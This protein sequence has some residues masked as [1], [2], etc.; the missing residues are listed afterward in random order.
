MA[1]QDK[2]LPKN[3]QD[4]VNTVL[5]MIDSGSLDWTKGWDSPSYPLAPV[6]AITGTRYKGINNAM[7]WLTAIERGYKDNRWLTF[8]QMEQNGWSFKKNEDGTSKGKG[9]GVPV[10]LFRYYDSLTKKDLDWKEF[11]KLT[12]DEQKD[13]WDKNVRR[14]VRYH[15]VFNAELVDGIAELKD[16]QKEV[17]HLSPEERNEKAEATIRDWNDKQCSI[18]HNGGE[19]A[20]YRP[21]TDS[22]H[23]PERTRFHSLEDYYGTALHEIGHATGHAKRLNRDLTGGF[24]SENYAKE[25]LKAE[26]AS[27][28]I[29][30]E[31][32]LPMSEFHIRNH[33][34]YLQ[35]WKK[36]ITNNPNVLFDAIKDAGKITSYVLENATTLQSINSVSIEENF[37]ESREE[38]SSSEKLELGKSKWKA[39]HLSVECCKGT[40]DSRCEFTL[41][42]GKYAGWDFSHPSKLV[43]DGWITD[44]LQSDTHKMCKDVIYSDNYS[45]IL[46]NGGKFVK[47]S[48]KELVDSFDFSEE[49]QKPSASLIEMCSQ[50]DTSSPAKS[51][52][53]RIANADSPYLSALLGED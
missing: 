23:L 8:N 43:T 32:Q 13:Y 21:S 24:G 38:S 6:S 14:I 18:T 9:A 47:L 46:K 12:L 45:F 16:V 3:R 26:F 27:M 4:L 44:D 10:E 2:E 5:S 34:A 11:N 35:S 29:Q 20:F 17:T 40:S 42:K 49:A 52:T 1:R 39:F 48:G 15:T 36:A 50:M 22:I 51:Y 25:E 19:S 33:S 41:D 28:F 7:L 30:Q 37:S 53:E 31:L